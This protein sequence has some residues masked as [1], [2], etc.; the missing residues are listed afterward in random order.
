MFASTKR[1]RQDKPEQRWRNKC[2]PSCTL[3]PQPPQPNTVE[4]AKRRHGV[5]FAGPNLA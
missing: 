2:I 5:G 4:V 1:Q 3:S